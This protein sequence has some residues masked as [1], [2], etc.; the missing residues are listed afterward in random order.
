MTSISLKDFKRNI[1]YEWEIL[2]DFRADM[3]VPIRVFASEPQWCGKGMSRS[4]AKRNVSSEE[5]QNRF[6]DAG[7]EIRA[8][9]MAGLAEEAP[10]AY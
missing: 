2:Q 6:E 7:I 8:G 9:S 5:L 4:K 1:A 10:D 3:R